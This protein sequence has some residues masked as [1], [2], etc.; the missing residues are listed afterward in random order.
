MNQHLFLQSAV[1]FLLAT[2]LMVPLAR[3]FQ[4]GAVLGYLAGGVLI[5]PSLLGLVPNDA[6]VAQLSELGVV[7][8]L[9]VIGLELSPQRLWVMRRAVF[10]VG[11]AQ[12]TTAAL[13]IGALARFGFGLG[14]AAAV[15]VGLGL[16]LSSTAFG[17][18]VLAERKELGSAHGRLGFAV[19]LFQDLAAIPLIAAV[20]LLA[21]AAASHTALPNLPA[22]TRTVAVIVAVIVGGRLLLRPLFRAVA[23]T[24]V[25]EVFTATAL[26]VVIGTAWL[27]ELAGISMA[28]GAFLA[29][30]LLADSEYRHELEAQI[31]PFKGLLLGLFFI[32]VGMSA[33]L[34]LLL[35]EPLVVVGLVA[36]LLAVKSALLW[37]LARLVGRIDAIAAL[38]LTAL[39]AGGGEFAFVVFKIAGDRHLLDRSQQSLLVLVITLSMAL[40]P[41][42]V[43]AAGW[44][45]RRLDRAPARPFDTIETD[46]PRVIIAGFGRVG[47]IVARVLRAHRI[48]FVA[49][50][51]SIEQVESSRRFGTQIFFG[52]PSRPEL[53]RAAQADRA[54]IFVLATDDPETNIRTAR[55]VRRL[56]PHL[57]IVAR[58]RNRQHAY[59]LMDLNVP[60]VV[61]ETFHSS[62]EMTRDVLRALGLD[63]A[64]V[65][66]HIARFREHDEAML[67]AQYLVYDDEAALIQNAR[68]ALQEL[69]SLFAADAGESETEA[70]V[71]PEVS[72]D[73]ARSG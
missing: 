18:Q 37:P 20:P 10:G 66:A 8:L 11:W 50:E 29:G 41:L 55:I 30:V 46:A 68:E 12:V 40:T 51:H 28:L 35:R 39:L 72:P 53:L 23:A 4:L 17:L 71:T 44:L 62:L 1:V 52:D 59:R 3:R 5:G 61:R 67:R 26:L 21:G 58:A 6:R 73:G 43:G 56:F 22:L 33:N 15:V 34:G 47:Q 16:A 24:R 70:A 14:T 7:L 65:D 69:E 57:R 9:F 13:A 2:V 60:M 36:L 38:R 42:L 64:T 27:M 25:A 63:A 45:A 54:E 48:P 32:S 31:E 49:L 19:L